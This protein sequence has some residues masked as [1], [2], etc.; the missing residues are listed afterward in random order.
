MRLRYKGISPEKPLS[1]IYTSYRTN[2]TAMP[3]VA[4]HAYDL[5]WESNSRPTSIFIGFIK[6]VLCFIIWAGPPLVRPSPL[7]PPPPLSFFPPPSLPFSPPSPGAGR[8]EGRG[9]GGG[10]GEGGSRAKKKGEIPP[11][12]PP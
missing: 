3:K 4:L 12:L 1:N 2:F 5:G 10:G 6:Y 8:G 7:S 9:K 11:P